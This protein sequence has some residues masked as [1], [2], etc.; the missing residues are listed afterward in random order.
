MISFA[1]RNLYVVNNIASEAAGVEIAFD[2]QSRPFA[3][4]APTPV[5]RKKVHVQSL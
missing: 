3:T 4:T 5:A 2:A 1:G